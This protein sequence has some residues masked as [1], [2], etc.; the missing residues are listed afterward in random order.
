MD[1]KG[2]RPAALCITGNHGFGRCGGVVASLAMGFVITGS[3]AGGP[4]DGLARALEPALLRSGFH[5]ASH[6]L[7][8]SPLLNP[9][10]SESPR[11][12]RRRSR[13]TFVAARHALDA[14]PADPLREGYPILV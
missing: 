6:D 3:V 9:V 13:G 4:L 11:P 10:G 8:P 12:F 5:S 2:R 7:Q 14:A 1:S